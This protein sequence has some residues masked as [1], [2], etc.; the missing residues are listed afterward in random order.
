MRFPP[1]GN[2]DNDEVTA[3]IRSDARGEGAGDQRLGAY[4][5]DRDEWKRSKKGRDEG[6]KR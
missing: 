4:D 5:E 2:G 1:Q 3:V 6:K